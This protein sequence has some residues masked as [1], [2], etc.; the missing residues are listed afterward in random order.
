MSSRADAIELTFTPLNSARRRL[1]LETLLDSIGVG[2]TTSRETEVEPKSRRAA[3]YRPATDASVL[4]RVLSLLGAPVGSKNADAS[5]E[6]PAYLDSAPDPIRQEFV[7]VYL[8]Y[9]GVWR[10]ES[11]ILEFR[12]ERSSSYLRAL[13]RLIED[14]AGAPVS[15][16]EHNVTLSVAATRAVRA[17]HEIDD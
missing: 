3:E 5:I 10:S 4:G 15:S 2:C 8:R 1:R 12:E 16:S 17:S 13:A 14:V 6:L 9:R 11:R 7:E